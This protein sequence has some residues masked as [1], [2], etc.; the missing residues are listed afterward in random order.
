MNRA[1]HFD[2]SDGTRCPYCRPAAN[3]LGLGASRQPACLS[4]DRR[5]HP[6]QEFTALEAL[7]DKS[8]KGVLAKVG[9]MP[10]Y[11]YGFPPGRFGSPDSPSLAR[12]TKPMTDTLRDPRLMQARAIRNAIPS[13]TSAP[14]R[15]H[16]P[17]SRHPRCKPASLPVHVFKYK[18]FTGQTSSFSP[19]IEKQSRQNV[20]LP[21]RPDV[22]RWSYRIDQC[23]SRPTWTV[24][25]STVPQVLVQ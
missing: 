15:T 19:S 7:I 3:L 24:Y 17:P 5:T 18:R 25:G 23:Q 13:H 4:P 11:Q 20:G 1:S 6:R 22:A 14:C 16:R 10:Q 9:P 8:I 2:H 12:C 21:E